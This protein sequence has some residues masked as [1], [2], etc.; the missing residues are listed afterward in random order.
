MMNNGFFGS[1]GSDHAGGANFGLADGSV[2][3]VS[4]AIDPTSSPCWAAWRTTRASP[5]PI[6][7]ARIRHS[8]PT[9]RVVASN[10]PTE[11]GTGT[12]YAQRPPGRSGKWCLS[13]FPTPS[14]HPTNPGENNGNLYGL[15]ARKHP[16]P[17]GA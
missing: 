15:H 13:P 17:G 7:T 4:S 5:S 10:H 6:K 14:N 11:K 16:R 3:F 1:P 9:K 12:I 8:R 2:T